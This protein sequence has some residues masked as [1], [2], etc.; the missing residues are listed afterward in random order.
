MATR[1]HHGGGPA[2]A[3]NAIAITPHDTTAVEPCRAL[4]VGGAG[5]LTVRMAAE[6]GSTNVLFAVVAGAVLPLSVR[7]V[8]ATGT[9][10]TGIVALY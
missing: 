1:R 4:Y 3:A 10:A 5:N 6:T 8:L 9:T 7:L 2:H